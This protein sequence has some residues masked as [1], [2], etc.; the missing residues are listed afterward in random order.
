MKITPKAILSHPLVLLA[1]RWFLA[2]VFI[3]AGVSKIIDP[4]SFVVEL[5]AYAIFPD[6]LLNLIALGLPPLELLLGLAMIAGPF[7]REAA[8]WLILLILGFGG[9]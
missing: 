2:F 5:K 6:V 7:I 1:C 3:Y 8:A 4:Q 9:G